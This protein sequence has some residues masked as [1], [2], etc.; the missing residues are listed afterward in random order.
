[1]KALLKYPI[2]L[3]Q[4]VVPKP[5]HSHNDCEYFH[6]C[7]AGK[8]YCSLYKYFHSLISCGGYRSLYRLAI[9]HTVHSPLAVK[10]PQ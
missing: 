3:T 10:M 1:M 9:G 8:R 6:E 7:L 4:G 5:I 2:H